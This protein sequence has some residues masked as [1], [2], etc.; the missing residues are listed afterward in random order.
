[1]I[2]K[3]PKSPSSVPHALTETQV[4]RCASDCPELRHRL[5]RGY[6]DRVLAS[7]EKA[8]L[9][10]NGEAGKQWLKR[11]E[12]EILTSKPELHRRKVCCVFGG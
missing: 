2:G 3:S 11:N 4:N 1:M 9:C 8:M 7:D 10:G 6:L 5:N 12:L